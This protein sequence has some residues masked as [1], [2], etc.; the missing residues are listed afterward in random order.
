MG[1]TWWEVL[2]GLFRFADTAPFE[3]D[4]ASSCFDL[5]LDR[6]GAVFCENSV[7][8]RVTILQHLQSSVRSGVVTPL[9]IDHPHRK[10]LLRMSPAN[11]ATLGAHCDTVRALWTQVNASDDVIILDSTHGPAFL[12][13]DVA[14]RA[15][16]VVQLAE[17]FCGGFAGWTQAAWSL[18]DAGAALHTSWLLDIE[19]ELQ[20]TLEA[21]IPSLQTV[22]TASELEA[23][24][25]TTDTVLL[26]ANVEHVWWHQ[27]W[28]SLPPDMLVC[29]PPCQPW[30][31]AGAQSGLD[32]PDGRLILHMIAVLQVVRVPVVCLEEVPGFVHHRDFQQILQAWEEAGY[33][34]I[35]REELQLA[36]VA[37]TWRKRCMMVF[38]HAQRMPHACRALQF[39]PWVPHPRP[40]LHGM[41]AYFHILP[42]DIVRTCHVSDEALEMYMDPWYL[43]PGG[44]QDKDAVCR[45]RL[46]APTQQ[47]RAF[48]AAY[49]RQHNLP[50]GML[51]RKG[52]LCSLLRVN[53]RIRFFSAPEIASC[54]GA[55][56]QQLFVTDDA[57]C[58]QSLG[59]AL[60]VPQAALIL[61]HALSCFP[62]VR[63]VAPAEA[64]QLVVA[65]RL[66]AANSA[67]FRVNAGWLMV[68][69]DRV[70]VALSQASLRLQIEGLL[71]SKGQIFHELRLGEWLGSDGFSTAQT[72]PFTS[73]LSLEAALQCLGVPLPQVLP[74]AVLEGSVKVYQVAVDALP[75]LDM[76]AREYCAHQGFTPHRVFTAAGQ[77]LCL[78]GT[79]D[80]FHQL[81]W[82]FDK[83]RIAGSPGVVCLSCYGAKYTDAA[84][85]PKQFF[86]ASDAAHIY[87][88][89]PTFT[90][91]QVADCTV[92]EHEQGL[93]LC[94]GS[95]SECEW[96]L[97][98]PYHLLECVGWSLSAVTGLGTGGH[99]LHL[100]A[101]PFADGPV[102]S[103]STV[104]VYLR[105]LLFLAQL[106]GANQGRFIGPFVIQV[107]TRTLRSL[108]LSSGLKPS[109]LEA[110]WH[111]ACV[112]T[113]CWPVAQVFSGPRRLPHDDCLENLLQTGAF[114]VQSASA[115]PILSIFPETRGGGVKDENQQLAKTK[116][117]T[118]LLERG[119]P[120]PQTTVA[121]DSLLAAA[122]TAPCLAAMSLTGSAAQWRQLNV[123][124]KAVGQQ[125][126]T[127]DNRTER[128]AQRIQKALRRRKLAQSAPVAAN[129]FSLIEGTWCGIDDQ[130]VA[131]LTSIG[132][133][134]NGVI[135]MEPSQANPQDLA[136]LCNIGA[137]ALCVVVPGHCCPD[138]D[139]CSG[140]ASVP[141]VHRETG[142]KHLLAVCYH[143]VGDTAISPFV[144]HGSQVELAGT[145]CCTLSM[146]RDECPTEEAW[147]EAVQAPVRTVA[148]AFK[149]QGLSG[150]FS[151]P[152][153][154]SFRASGRPSQPAHC[155]VFLFQAK[156]EEGC[157]RQLL[158]LSGFNR[159]YVVPKAWN[160]SVL[161]GWSVIWMSASRGEIE[162]QA[163]L[164]PEQH[165]LVRGK[166][167]Y[168]I[169]VPT[170]DFER[171]FRQLRPGETVPVS[172]DVRA[173]YKVGPLPPGATADAVLQWAKQLHWQLRVLKTLGP[174]FWLVGAAEAPP[175]ETLTFNQQP[176][177]V[178]PVKSR[179][180]PQPVLQAGGP[181]PV[182]RKQTPVSESAD[183]WLHNDPWSTYR[184][185][186]SAG[187]TNSVLPS[188]SPP[189][190]FAPR[191][192][193][194]QLQ[195]QLQ[196]QEHRLTDLENTLK[197]LRD[198]QEAA[199]RERALDKQQFHHDI[200][201][202][203]TEVQG[204]GAGLRQQIQCQMDSYTVAQKNHEQQMAAGMEE[205]KALIMS[206]AEVR[207]ARKLP[208]D[209]L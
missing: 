145:V 148:Q 189:A 142:C 203:R 172:F 33:V 83:C 56:R 92:R 2:R 131:I 183:P 51:E 143:N 48:M 27:V 166:S 208:A 46:C 94:I 126:P 186:Q 100:L 155:D 113:G 102:A 116:M 7:L 50:P 152:W 154:R 174:Q 61:A 160:R 169:R 103:A 64:V 147:Q 21:L 79:P 85:L 130:P 117:A 139:T 200:A 74:P 70:G 146:H 77:F 62:Q 191:V 15:D 1:E 31:S 9:S 60:A 101:A 37:P 81:K 204:L 133:N 22:Q 25:D 109:C 11:W 95:G 24:A 19:D 3:L 181:L 149:P 111:R 17:V 5:R 69:V 36:E 199:A 112:A 87:H 16:S 49:H 182:A 161:E 156:V 159:V 165:G 198:D 97:Q 26:L 108:S 32:S 151:H 66:H 185:K 205:L 192:A 93:L 4:G 184:A 176:V 44:R 138:T 67:L 98:A 195:S 177:L 118:L 119:V 136:L 157:L 106:R 8:V 35:L 197:G 54:H 39:Q 196:A 18:Q 201:A 55:Q 144:E 128:A 86:V 167:R 178:S 43:P 73:H 75:M 76:D 84:R 134:A 209:E 137:D 78:S 40:S 6:E 104:R 80:F 129:D 71:C 105:D 202:V 58:M 132:P 12:A 163:A 164:M 121:V 47:A 38:A 190:S 13:G 194:T 28:A 125:L 96:A 65:G 179:E 91:S 207:K 52:L 206:T 123:H 140:K 193:A 29:S 175:S 141:V 34:C 20:A 59:N 162:R 115:C 82:I 188:P 170:R 89:A 72:V 57:R 124:A 173:L 110:M 120:L 23:L 42:A 90:A 150:P 68:R 135:L 45:F 171:L 127:G 180:N 158:R 122:G 99:S 107:Q 168:G 10:A 114:H 41:R 187:S 14:L 30:S 63:Q 153:G 53:N 88:H